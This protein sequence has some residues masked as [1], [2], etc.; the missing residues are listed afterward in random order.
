M[1]NRLRQWFRRLKKHRLQ[2]RQ[3]EAERLINPYIR[4]RFTPWPSRPVYT[5]HHER[6]PAKG[7]VRFQ[8]TRSNHD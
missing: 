8:R 2:Q 4:E 1:L 5:T 6:G 3:Q 7:R